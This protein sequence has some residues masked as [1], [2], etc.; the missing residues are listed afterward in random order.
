MQAV[1]AR[2][3]VMATVGGDE[4]EGAELG[5]LARRGDVGEEEE[6]EEACFTSSSE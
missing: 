6:E 3:K 1:T 4:P 2:K 5:A